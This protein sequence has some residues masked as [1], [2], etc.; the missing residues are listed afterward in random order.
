MIHIYKLFND[1]KTYIGSTANPLTVRLAQH[2]LS[3]HSYK[4]GNNSKFISSYDI[5]DE[6]SFEIEL[7][8]TCPLEERFKREQHWMNLI[9]NINKNSAYT[10]IIGNQKSRESWA[11][12]QREH[13]RLN[14]DAHLVR[15]NRYYQ[16][17]KSKIQNKYKIV[18][19]FQSLPYSL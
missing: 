1:S 3:H 6:G 14:R 13:Y 18:K 7:L 11:A 17:N 8:E 10:G 12:Y 4:F 5:I 9:P 19:L 16:L 2:I 15:K